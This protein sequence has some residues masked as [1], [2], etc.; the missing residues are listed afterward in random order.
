MGRMPVTYIFVSSLHFLGVKL[1]KFPIWQQRRLHAPQAGIE[2]AL[3]A[4]S[5]P[6]PAAVVIYEIHHRHGDDNGIANKAPRI[7]ELAEQE[8]VER[9]AENDLRVVVYG[10]LARRSECDL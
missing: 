2:P 1:K 6:A 8:K 4:R 10:D 5:F 7:R 3:F 9:G